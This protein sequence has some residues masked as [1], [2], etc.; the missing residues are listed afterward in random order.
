VTGGMGTTAFYVLGA[1]LTL[2]ALVLLI[3]GKRMNGIF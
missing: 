2:A 1:I 3:T